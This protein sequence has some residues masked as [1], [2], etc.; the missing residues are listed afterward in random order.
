MKIIYPFSSTWKRVSSLPLPA[1]LNSH[2][3]LR[4]QIALP[5]L[6]AVYEFLKV[7]LV[8]L[9]RAGIFEHR[10]VLGLLGDVL[11]SVVLDIVI[12]VRLVLLLLLELVPIFN[13]LAEPQRIQLQVA[14]LPGASS[15]VQSI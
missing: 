9:L 7:S 14:L 6:L 2:F 4:L 12:S 1:V 11:W 8:I 3:V 15:A 5:L 13:F 10:Q